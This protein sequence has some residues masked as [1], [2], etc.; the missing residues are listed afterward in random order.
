MI[1]IV[2]LNG[3]RTAGNTENEKTAEKIVLDE[4]PRA[5]FDEWI[6]NAEPEAP[7]GEYVKYAYS[8]GEPVVAMYQT[9]GV[10]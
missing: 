1:E 2:F 4:Y 5:T 6:Q 7:E 8:D 3:P 10:A 9:E